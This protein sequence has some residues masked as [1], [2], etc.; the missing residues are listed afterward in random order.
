MERDQW[1]P[2]V[3]D[4]AEEQGGLFTA[5]Q[6]RIAGARRPQLADLLHAG[7]IERV[8]HGIYRLSGV[9]G[10]RWESARAAW[11]AL[12]PEASASERLSDPAG[13]GGVLSHRTAARMFDLGDIDADRIDLTTP[14]PRTTR[15]PEVSLHTAALSRGQ[16]IL[17][18]GLPVTRPEVIVADLAAAGTDV[19]HLATITRDAALKH[20]VG[21]SALA[22]ALAPHARAHGHADGNDFLAHLLNLAGAPGPAVD[23]GVRAFIDEFSKILAAYPT[24]TTEHFAKALTQVQVPDVE[25]P[26]IPFPQVDLPKPVLTPEAMRVLQRHSEEVAKAVDTTAL[27]QVLARAL[28]GSPA[29]DTLRQLRE[30]LATW[31]Y[32]DD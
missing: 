30:Q 17:Q 14:T 7:A 5:A 2:S 20:N 10:D 31:D 32:T 21:T 11:L 29:V 16:W 8:Q 25:I 26:T 27:S 6:A 12:C 13:S 3:R 23:V 9:P 15:N 19:E 28:E 4:L 24:M 22:A 1:W 18:A